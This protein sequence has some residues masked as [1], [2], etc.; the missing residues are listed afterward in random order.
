M[1]APMISGALALA[2]AE[3][4]Y[5]SNSLLTDMLESRAANIYQNG[6]NAAYEDSATDTHYLGEGR[7]DIHHFIYDVTRP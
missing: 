5:I 6:L 7:L 1:A 2:L 4:R 3:T